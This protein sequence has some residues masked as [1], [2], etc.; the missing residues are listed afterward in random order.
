MTQVVSEHVS[1]DIYIYVTVM[2]T[3]DLLYVCMCVCGIAN[4]FLNTKE[5]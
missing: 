5:H 4:L 3:V 2:A 1:F